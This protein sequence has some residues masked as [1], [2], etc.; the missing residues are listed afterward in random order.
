LK[1][2][3]ELEKEFAIETWKLTCAERLATSR[4]ANGFRSAVEGKHSH[5]WLL[6]QIIGLALY[7]DT[8]KLLQ[9]QAIQIDKTKSQ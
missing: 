9:T 5:L 8:S 4:L 2:E 7:D 3:T 6:M 1:L